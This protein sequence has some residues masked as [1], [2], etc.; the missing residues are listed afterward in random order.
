ML[1]L[2]CITAAAIT[3]TACAHGGRLDT[4]SGFANLGEDAQHS[5]RATSSRGVFVTARTEAND[6]AGNTMFWADTVDVQLKAR[7][8]VADGAKA[9]HSRGGLDGTELHYLVTIDGRPH[10]YWVAVFA[11]KKR[12]FVVEAA[13]DQAIFDASSPSVEQAI[14]SLDAVE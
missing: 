6:I 4:P 10:R 11:T 5:Y 13:G 2:A 7:G 3:F 14:A 8:Y 1:K 12:V 9:V